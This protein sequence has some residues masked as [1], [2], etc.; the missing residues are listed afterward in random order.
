MIIIPETAI[1]ISETAIIISETAIIIPETVIIIPETVIITPE[2]VII[3]PETVII[4]PETV[5]IT[6]E[7]VII[8]PET[9]IITPE[10][11]IIVPETVIIIPETVIIIPETN[12]LHTEH[13]S[14]YSHP[15][16][17]FTSYPTGHTKL[18]SHP[19]SVSHSTLSLPLRRVL[20]EIRSPHRPAHSKSPYQLRYPGP[21]NS[22]GYSDNFPCHCYDLSPIGDVVM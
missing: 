12:H 8:I 6:P 11:V 21:S 9:V 10:T 2:T 4:I 14:V 7:T 18:S 16:P 1:I 17:H 5:I 20:W 13:V 22:Y 19:V 15:C 3:I